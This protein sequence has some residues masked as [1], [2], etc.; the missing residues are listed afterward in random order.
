M[1]E[2]ISINDKVAKEINES[3]YSINDPFRVLVIGNQDL[4]KKKYIK[5]KSKYIENNQKGGMYLTEESD[6][7]NVFV[8]ES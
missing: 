8:S 5:Y 6:R 7:N 1:N 3:R 4:F 2:S